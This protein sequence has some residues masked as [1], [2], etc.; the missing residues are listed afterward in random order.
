MDNGNSRLQQVQQ[1]VDEVTVIMHDNLNKAEER[2][3]KMTDLEGRA[4]LLRQKSKKFNK[5]TTKVKQKMWWENFRMKVLLG[6]IAVLLVLAVI[7]I[8]AVAS[9]GPA[10]SPALQGTSQDRAI[11]TVAPTGAV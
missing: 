6:A 2:S 1:T 7:I 11:T 4:E 9:S 10:E 3:E 5:N 8:V